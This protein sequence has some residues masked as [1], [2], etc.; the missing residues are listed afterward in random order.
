[1]M[2]SFYLAAL[3]LLFS[4]PVFAEMPAM[5]LTL[6]ECYELALRQSET[7]AIRQEMI[8]ETRGQMQQALSTALPKVAFSYAE[9][10][11]DLDGRKT[12]GGSTPDGKFTLTQ[13][14]FTGFKEFAAVG[15]SRHVGRQ[16]NAELKR[17]KELLFI[18]VSDAF[19]LYLSCQ[20]DLEVLEE[21]VK[22]LSERREELKRRQAIGRSRPGEV[23]SV[24]A[25]MGRLHASV[26]KVRG[27]REIA[28]QLME[29]LIGRSFDRLVEE[30]LPARDL[31]PED[32]PVKVESRADITAAHENLAVYGSQVTSARSAFFPLVTLAGNSYTK[33]ADAYEGNDWDA[34]LTVSVPLFNGL[35]D[36]GALR[37]ARSGREQARLDLEAVRRRAL[38]EVRQAV[39][40]RQLTARSVKALELAV[41]SAGL[42]YRLQAQDFQKSLVSNLDVLQALE[43]LHLLRREL[44][45]ARADEAR[46]YWSLLVA[47]GGI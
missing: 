39:V 13:P 4:V 7:V 11:E 43:D 5:G 42:N 30:D 2:R 12:W 29:F 45:A 41:E 14:L 44:V 25:K 21:S 10:W 18:D 34:T 22:I 3:V 20:Q 24:E 17:A 6:R 32:L 23:A 16:R 36:V 31:K 19:Y 27:Q 1:M 38:L 9:K 28:A 33:R 46:A 35:S 26:E 8:N 15:A 47:T 40:R 37:E